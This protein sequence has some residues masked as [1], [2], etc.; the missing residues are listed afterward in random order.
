MAPI[1]LAFGILKLPGGDATKLGLVLGSSSV[2]LLLMFPF[3]GVI[4]DRYGRA[5][6]V[7]IGRAHV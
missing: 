6:L 5:R 4:A 2:T 1:A 3:G 7:E